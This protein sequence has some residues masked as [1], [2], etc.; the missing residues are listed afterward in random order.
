MLTSATS[1]QHQILILDAGPIREL[2]LF[3]AVSEFGFEKLRDDLRFIKDVE[4]YNRC[5]EF[6]GTFSNRLTTSAGV[7]VELYHWIRD[8]EKHGQSRL[9]GR[10]YEQFR[11]MGMD[12]QVVQLVAMDSSLVL[13]CGPV[14][15]SLLEI[16]RRHLARNPLV[17]TAD[18]PFHW[19][20]INSGVQVSHLDQIATRIA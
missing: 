10:V 15:T 4:S 17:L 13:R 2:V 1:K 14:D 12:E 19:E 7:V 18:W 5:S 9:W 20:C 6:V 3:H 8:T 16:A 11:N